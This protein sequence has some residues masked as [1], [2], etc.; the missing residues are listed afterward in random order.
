MV[1]LGQYN[2][3]RVIKNVDF[4]VYL[5][6]DGDDQEIL[7]PLKY[8]PENTDIG[9]YLNVF[10]YND[11]EN[12]IIA[13]TLEPYATVGEFAYLTVVDVTEHGAFLDMGIAKDVFV[14]EKQQ[15]EKMRLGREYVV[16]LYIDEKSNRI[17]ATMKW[18]KFIFQDELDLA[19]GD[20]VRIIV[21]RKT[22]LGYTVIVND[23][24]LGLVYQND[25]FEPIA[26]G[27]R[28]QA[29]V[30]KIR[31]ENKLDISLRKQ[32]FEALKESKDVII[33]YLNRNGGILPLGD[34]SSPDDIY[35]TL[36]LSKKAFKKLAGNL[37]KEGKI[38]IS[39]FEI[40]LNSS[41]I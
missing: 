27:D 10:V 13:T 30:K 40:K 12:R 16:Y 32:G 25:I 23:R 3:L 4:G 38:M 34:K 17:A 41:D 2:R 9:D 8:V 39:D 24:Y 28:K 15:T 21:V 33:N 7:L 19:E 14:P 31:E 6:Q 22:D 20:E 11:S 29:F 18:N 1:E 26:V 5:S 37:Y 35:S 36:H